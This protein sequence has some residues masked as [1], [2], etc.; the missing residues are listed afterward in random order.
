MNQAEPRADVYAR[1]TSRIIEDLEKVVRPWHKPWSAS[2]A[3]HRLPALPL[4]HNDIP[5]R[6]INILL[7]WGQAIENGYSSS[8]WM[9]YKQ[10]QELGGQ[11]RKGERGSLVVFADVL[12]K[13]EANDQGEEIER[14][15]PFMKGYTIEV[16]A[17]GA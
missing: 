4:R 1:A 7:L 6:G 9:T 12:H 2:N 13:T 5:Y 16:I 17:N 3:A 8:R 14:E 15:I 10:A 11:V